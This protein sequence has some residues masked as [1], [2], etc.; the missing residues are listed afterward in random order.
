MLPEIKWCTYVCIL[1]FE[2]IMKISI[3][4]KTGL[5]SIMRLDKSTK[6]SHLHL[7]SKDNL[8]LPPASSILFFWEHF[9]QCLTGSENY[10]FWILH[11]AVVNWKCLK[12]F[13]NVCSLTYEIIM[14][15]I[16]IYL[17]ELFCVV[18]LD[19]SIK[20]SHFMTGK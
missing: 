19:I 10:P 11:K 7:T 15:N 6:Y 1:T 13:T 2:I 16:N 9:K 4:Y 14:K 18:W 8:I 12:N 3:F 17:S 20:Y 5:F